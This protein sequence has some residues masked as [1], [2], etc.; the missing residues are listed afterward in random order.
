MTLLCIKRKTSCLGKAGQRI[1]Y[2]PSL[3]IRP[4]ILT[5]SEVQ[6]SRKLHIWNKKL[7]HLRKKIIQW[8]EKLAMRA[9]N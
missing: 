6:K 2:M 1:D 3:S 9:G 8:R 5:R 4:M 7:V